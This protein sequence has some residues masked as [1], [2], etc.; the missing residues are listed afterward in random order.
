[1]IPNMYKIA[2]ELTPTVFHI[3]A[4][5]MATHALSI[6]GDHSDVMAARG[7]GFALLASNNPQEAQDFALIAQAA[8]LHGRIPVL[9]FFDGFRTS[10]EVTKIEQIDEDTVRTLIRGPF[11]AAHRCAIAV[12]RASAAARQLRR[13]RTCSS[14]RGSG[15]IPTTTPSPASCRRRWT[16]SPS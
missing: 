7:T 6:F 10:H 3:A 14:R 5:S 2:G 8:T 12:A 13:I 1:M 11:V 15:S 9:H 4:R 16:A